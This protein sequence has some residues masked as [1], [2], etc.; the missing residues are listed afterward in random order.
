MTTPPRPG[1][2]SHRRPV[3]ARTAVRVLV[4]A[5]LAAGI[6]ALVVRPWH[7]HRGAT[8]AETDHPMPGDDLV[9]HPQ[10]EATHAITIAAPPRAVWPWLTQ[11]ADDTPGRWDRYVTIDGAG[12]EVRAI[13]PGRSLV[14]TIDDRDATASLTI[15]LEPRD[16][17][18]TRLVLRLRVQ[19]TPTWRGRLLIA[20]VDVGDVV[21]MRRQLVGI[22]ER[23]QR[24]YRRDPFQA[25]SA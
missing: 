7:L 22:R 13:D 10:L 4:G 6:Y 12:F 11:M 25:R 14:A 5:G 24:T 20:A 16:H 23:A 21:T 9:P 3:G 15:T 19:A 2:T 18:R 8:S 17:E 1:V